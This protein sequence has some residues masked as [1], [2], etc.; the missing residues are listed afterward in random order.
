MDPA[1]R[2]RIIATP[3]DQLPAELIREYSNSAHGVPTNL[4]DL[5]A[6]LP[7]YLD[8]LAQG[9]AV[10][11]TEVGCALSRFG[12]ALRAHP[13]FLNHTQQQA[14]A[15]WARHLLSACCDPAQ[16][17][18][19][20]TNPLSC[21]EML[22]LGGVPPHEVLPHLETLLHR[23]TC[24]GLFAEAFNAAAI[25]RESPDLYAL[26]L[27]DAATQAAFRDWLMGP[28]LLD[29][30]SDTATDPDT[31]FEIADPARMAAE[32]LLGWHG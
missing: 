24:L 17:A 9:V 2:D 19:H 22:L 16:A 25:G 26:S 20:D 21:V 23:P 31:P 28:K 27:T 29:L 12:Y 13:D 6:L 3:C 7:R 4:D 8:L 32:R 1:T 18:H 14:Y 30:F 10:D 11:L 15:N 5:R